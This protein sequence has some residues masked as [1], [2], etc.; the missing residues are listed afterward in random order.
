MIQQPERRPPLYLLT[1]IVFGLLVGTL[2]AW[3]LWPAHITNVGPGNLAA[4]YKEQY[5]L[6]VALAFASSGD[7]GRAEARLALLGDGDPV[8][9][10][11]SQAQVALANTST[12][13]EARALAGLAEALRE[14]LAAQQEAEVAVNTPNPEQGEVSTPFETGANATYKLSDQDLLCES[15]ETPAYLKIFVF[16][17]NGN[18]QAGVNLS[19]S[20]P[21]DVDEFATGLMPEFGPGY[22]E[23]EMTPNTVYTLSIQGVEVMG[24]IKAAA[25][26]TEAGEPAWGSWLLLFNQQD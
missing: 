2:I 19:M 13:R 3:L 17:P 16:D 6:Q 15:A 11:A 9:M 22:A 23:Y 21:E 8:R 18:P 4:E 5:R 12:Q 7:I 14:H 25:C 1:G 20:Y 26:E 10:L 24:G